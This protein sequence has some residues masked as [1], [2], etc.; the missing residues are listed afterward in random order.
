MNCASTRVVGVVSDPATWQSLG[1][2]ALP[3][4]WVELRVDALPPQHRRL[5]L[6]SPCP[7]PL[8]LTLRH[9]AEGGCCAWAGDERLQLARELLPAAAALD[10]EIAFIPGAE[11]LLAEAKS[12]GVLLIASAHFFHSTPSLAEMLALQERAAAAGADIVKIAFT[13]LSA[14][15]MEVGVHFLQQPRGAMHA[16]V[17]GMGSLAATS[18]ALYTR[19]GS[20]LLYGYL[21]SSPTAPGQ[22]SAAEC[23]KLIADLPAVNPS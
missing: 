6:A 13:P 22:L 20:S 2:G 8:L 3:C 11:S 4:D 17:M 16:A 9:P 19:F 7:K 12:R 14:D 18:R 21:G 5:A 1:Q 15:D 10:W 23:R